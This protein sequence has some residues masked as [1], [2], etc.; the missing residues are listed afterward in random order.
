VTEW[1]NVTKV[2]PLLRGRVQPTSWLTSASSNCG[3]PSPRRPQFGLVRG[4]G[5]TGFC[6]WH[7]W[8]A[9]RSLLERPLDEVMASKEPNFPFC[10]A[11]ANQPW[12][13][14][15]YEAP[16]RVPIE[17]TY[18]GPED[19]AR[20]FEYLLAAF[21]NDRSIRMAGPPLFFV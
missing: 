2:R 3:R 18:S 12:S 20:H 19:V 9:A 15:W 16:D 10:L 11:W 4:S 14:T 5:V 17:Q 1:T 13:G 8:F 6:D 7:Y 21:R